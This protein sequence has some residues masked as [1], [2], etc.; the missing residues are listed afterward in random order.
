MIYQMFINPDNLDL[1]EFIT[2]Y[3]PSSKSVN[4][5]AWSITKGVTA[6]IP[7]GTILGPEEVLYLTDDRWAGGWWSQDGQVI[8]WEDG[9]LSNS[10]ESIQLEDSH[11]IIIDFLAYVNDGA[12]LT[13]GFSGQ[14]VFQLIRPGLDNHFPESWTLDLFANVVSDGSTAIP[15]GF[16]VYPN[17]TKDLVTLE[18][19]DFRNQE[20]EIYNVGGQMLARARINDQG[21]ATLHLAVYKQG[22]LFIKVGNTVQKVVLIK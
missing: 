13:G 22:M 12:W 1:P 7:E 20:I 2:L 21:I 3:N 17:P 11:G 10:G 6:V 16:K 8:E 19:A 5:S 18:G 9:K 14:G 15:A 4:L